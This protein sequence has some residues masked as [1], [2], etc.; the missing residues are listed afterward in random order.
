ME[1]GEIQGFVLRL[2]KQ[3]NFKHNSKGRPFYLVL[4]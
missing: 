1:A 3:E 4:Q 2:V